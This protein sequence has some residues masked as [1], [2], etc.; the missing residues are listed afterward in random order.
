MA[1]AIIGPIIHGIGAWRRSNRNP[2]GI[3]MASVLNIVGSRPR[4]LVNSVIDAW[5]LPLP[6][7]CGDRMPERVLNLIKTT[8]RRCGSKQQ[9]KFSRE[10]KIMNNPGLSNFRGP[11]GS[12]GGMHYED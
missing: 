6:Y 5:L 12:G 11:K 1:T 8:L 9:K 4:R 7:D 2:A 3:P 10:S